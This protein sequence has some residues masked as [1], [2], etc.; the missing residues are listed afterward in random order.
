VQIFGEL[1]KYSFEILEL[2]KDLTLFPKSLTVIYIVNMYGNTDSHFQATLLEAA[3]QMQ[4]V[5]QP[6]IYLPIKMG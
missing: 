4:R 2:Q 6:S 5:Y 3:M 1:K